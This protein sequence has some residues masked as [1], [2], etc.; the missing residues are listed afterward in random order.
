MKI[1][2]SKKNFIISCA[3]GAVLG[4]ILFA[5]IKNALAPDSVK[6]AFYNLS[7]NQIEAIKQESKKFTERK[8]SYKFTTIDSESAFAKTDVDL[9]FTNMGATADKMSESIP[10]KKR[11]K[12]YLNSKVLAGSSISAAK[13]AR[14]DSN[15][16]V[17]VPLLFDGYELLLSTESLRK[18]NTQSINGWNE[19][20]TYAQ[21]ARES[22]RMPLVFAGKDAD[23]FLAVITVLTES[24]GGMEDCLKAQ[25]MILDF[26][27]D[28]YNALV[29]K[30][31]SSQGP[32]HETCRRLKKW[33]NDG[34][35]SPEV[36]RLSK[37]AVISLAEHH[38]MA[39]FIIPLSEHRNFS[40]EASR[41]FTTIPISSDEQLTFI[42]SNRPLNTRSIVSPVIC[43][44]PMTKNRNVSFFVSHLTSENAQERISNLTGLA[45]M[46]ARCHVPDIYSDDVRFWI[47]ASQVPTTPLGDSAF[48]SQQKKETVADCLRNYI[49]EN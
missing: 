42:P 41:K 37:S 34:I 49:L 7:E 39:S 31:V 15:K 40:D 22:Y 44:V 5:A 33:I 36:L 8:I 2:I 9:I 6:I 47:A 23:T 13:K 45:P 30:L 38:H 4:T 18:T 14:V 11:R 25:E 43:A 35:I 1:K 48:T 10:A 32:L 21:K 29:K 3:I 16:I 19:F 27:G 17:Q 26:T 46:H 12:T 28:D 24:F 20:E